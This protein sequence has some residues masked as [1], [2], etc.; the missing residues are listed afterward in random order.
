M[1]EIPNYIVASPGQHLPVKQM[2]LKGEGLGWFDPNTGEIAIEQGLDPV[3]KHHILFHEMIHLAAEKIEQ[4]GL[5]SP[6]SEEFVTYLTGAL[7]PMIVM[8][9]LWDGVKPEEAAEFFSTP[10]E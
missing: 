10:D 9:G 8:S 4:A 1:K 3:G 2:D 7:F 6:P 5:A